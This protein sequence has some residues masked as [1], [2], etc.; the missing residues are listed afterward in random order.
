MSVSV[1]MS[2]S[3]VEAE[4]RGTF[5]SVPPIWHLDVCMYTYMYIQ[6]IHSWGGQLGSSLA[7]T[8]K[9]K[10]LMLQIEGVDI[11]NVRNL[12]KRLMD[13]VLLL[14]ISTFIHTCCC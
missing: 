10:E 14:C 5:Y 3:Q 11:R 6:L 9:G 4:S 7:N 2:V 13:K 1:S 12:I 8:P